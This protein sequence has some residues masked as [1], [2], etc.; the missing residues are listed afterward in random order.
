MT[1]RARMV[2]FFLLICSGLIY[3]T[4]IALGGD[5]RTGHF[6]L[7]QMFSGVTNHTDVSAG[8]LSGNTI[9]KYPPSNG[10]SNYVLRT[11]GS[12]VSTWVSSIST[13]SAASSINNGYLSSADW[14]TF[15]NKVTNPMSALGDSMYGGALGA[16]TVLPGNTTAT[17]KFL[18]QTGDSVNSA[19]PGWS[20]IVASDFP[21]NAAL[22]TPQ[23]TT[24][25]ALLNLA[26]T[27]WYNTGSTQYVGFKAPTLSGN[28]IWTLPTT[29]GSTGQV[30]KTD[31]SG[32]LGWA[33]AVTNPMTA[34]GDIIYSSSGTGT[35]ARLAIGASTSVLHGGTTPSYAAVTL[36]TDVTGTL[37]V[38]N[39]GTGV[40]SSTG[41]GSNVLSTGPTLTTPVLIGTIDTSDTTVTLTVSSSR[42]ITFTS[43]TAGRTVTLPTTSIVAGDQF[44]IA[45]TTVQP[46]TLQ[47]SGANTV[48]IINTGYIVVKA[49]VSTPTTAGN[50]QVID[51]YSTLTHSTTWKTNGIGSVATSAKNIFLTRR[52]RTVTATIGANTIT[53]TSQQGS[54]ATRFD[55]Q[56]AIPSQYRPS[57]IIG[58]L[59]SIQNNNTGVAAPAAWRLITTGFFQLNYDNTNGS[60]VINNDNTGFSVVVVDVQQMTYDTGI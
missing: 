51:Y 22:T 53:G 28:Q 34:T 9:F 26:E 56:T 47:S 11:D 39:G 15:N 27:R 50:W 18:T 30:I 31:G 12:G 46:L 32:A 4:T 13:L 23:I 42:N 8:A 20:V 52:G 49:L 54:T 41:S 60:T 40:T 5:T 33:S 25:E 10:T 24:N 17:K 48:D 2:A 59:A 21:A 55:S 29:D 58:S 6:D 38:A 16:L 19:A 57:S 36:T 37:P 43:F 1:Y 3:L 7:L 45:N 14:T 35:P 44:L